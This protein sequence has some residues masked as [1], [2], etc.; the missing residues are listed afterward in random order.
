MEMAE[1]VNAIM[2]K[3]QSK[4]GLDFFHRKLKIDKSVNAELK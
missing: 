3:Q 4:V 2:K 1:F